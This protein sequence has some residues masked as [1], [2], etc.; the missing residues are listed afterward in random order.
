MH[1]VALV[2][3]REKATWCYAC[4]LGFVQYLCIQLLVEIDDV[5]NG[6]VGDNFM[7]MNYENGDEEIF[8]SRKAK[9]R[10]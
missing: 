4:F 5:Y 3:G 1:H 10:S 7:E 9:Q 2:V 8:N 6:S